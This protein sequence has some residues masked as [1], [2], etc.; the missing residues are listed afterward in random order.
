MAVFGENGA[1]FFLFPFSGGAD[2]QFAQTWNWYGRGTVEM[3]RGGDRTREMKEDG[4]R[5]TFPRT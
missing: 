2:S 5:G 1:H 4:S 3:C